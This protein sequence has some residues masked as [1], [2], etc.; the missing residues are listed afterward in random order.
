M[1]ALANSTRCAHGLGLKCLAC[2]PIQYNLGGVLPKGASTLLTPRTLNAQPLGTDYSLRYACYARHSGM[3]V[4]DRMTKDLDFYPKSSVYGFIL[5]M[6]DMLGLAL[7]EN[8]DMFAIGHHGAVLKSHIAFTDWLI[9]RF[10][11][12]SS[13]FLQQRLL[14]ATKD[15]DHDPDLAGSLPF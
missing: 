13:N 9:N 2:Y 1:T 12:P 5:F 4:L 15:I 10:P 6:D 14:D 3:T 11:N 8:P 7:N